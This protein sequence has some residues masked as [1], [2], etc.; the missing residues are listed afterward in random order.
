MFGAQQGVSRGAT[1]SAYAIPTAD[2]SGNPIALSLIAQLVAKF[3]DYANANPAVQFFVTRGCG[4]VGYA[5]KD[6]APMFAAAPQTAIYRKSGASYFDRPQS[7]RA[8]QGE[9]RVTHAV[10]FTITALILALAFSPAALAK[11]A[12]L[13]ARFQAAASL[14]STGKGTGPC[15]GYVIIKPLACGGVDRPSNMQWQTKERGS[16]R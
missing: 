4:I 5:D 1:G 14:P 15:P 10:C 6:I 12:Q 11:A 16:K 2:K 9:R 13:Q 8:N 7:V 3:I